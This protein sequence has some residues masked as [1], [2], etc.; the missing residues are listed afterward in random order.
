MWH[1]NSFLCATFQVVMY[2]K[3]NYCQLVWLCKSPQHIIQRCA[4][5][6]WCCEYA[7]LRSNS[8]TLH[9]YTNKAP[10]FLQLISLLRPS[11]FSIERVIYQ[12]WRKL[13]IH[14]L[15]TD[16]TIRLTSVT[17]PTVTMVTEERQSVTALS[18][19]NTSRDVK[20][21]AK[22][23]ATNR[24]WSVQQEIFTPLIVGAIW[25]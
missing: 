11:F 25:L 12:K 23:N 18:K 17:L 3:A 6:T 2:H 24:S 7:T 16:I 1:K 15:K 19:L 4:A 8:F 10:F 13:V 22:R 9:R 5:N 20:G 14:P 21:Q